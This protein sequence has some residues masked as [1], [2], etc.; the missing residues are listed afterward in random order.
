VIRALS[1]KLRHLLEKA[2][3]DGA[4]DAGNLAYLSLI[5]LFPAAILVVSI[6]ALVG[7][8]HLGQSVLAG[9][10][11]LLPRDIAD[12]LAPVVE[13]VA[14]ARA[15]GAISLSLLVALWTV[16]GFIETLR[17]ILHK[18][19]GVAPGRPFWQNRLLSI[20]AAILAAA[21]VFLSFWLGLLLQIVRR[22][23]RALLEPLGL[24]GY[25]T[26][27]TALAPNLVAFLALWLLLASLSPRSRTARH[28]PGALLVILVWSAAAILIGPLLGLFGGMA[29]T[30]GALSGVMVAL[31][32]F[33]LMGFALV[34][35]AELNAMLSK[36]PQQTLEE[37][38]M[39]ASGKTA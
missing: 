36:A 21:S 15:T 22:F 31:L 3:A 13:D 11:D 6:T 26:A 8:S 20:L 29:R 25:V 28:W 30:Y 38:A 18:A 4:T 5:T 35:G 19:Y 10:F 1:G 12:A 39:K 34:L 24:E 7:Q 37:A 16:S 27:L 9:F 23:L 33:Y 14:A 32:F 2:L 17:G